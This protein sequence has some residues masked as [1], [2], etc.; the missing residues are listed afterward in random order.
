MD[1]CKC[2]APGTG[3]GPVGTTRILR[4]S[5]SCWIVHVPRALSL[6]SQHWQR[7]LPLSSCHLSRSLSLYIYMYIYIHVYIYIY[8]F[9]ALSMHHTALRHIS[10]SL[11]LY[12]HIFIYI[13]IYIYTSSTDSASH[14]PSVSLSPHFQCLPRLVR[15]VTTCTGWGPVG[16]ARSLR[17]SR[18]A[19]MYTSTFT[20]IHICVYLSLHIYTCVYHTSSRVSSTYILILFAFITGN[21]SLEPL[22]EGLCAQI[23]VNLR[24]RVFGR[25]LFIYVYIYI[26]IYTRM[27]ITHLAECQAAISRETW[28]VHSIATG[29]GWGPVGRATGMM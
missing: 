13:Y 9:Q 29:T 1:M 11:L 28:L 24:W 2:V 23:H 6:S 21:S 3:W 10:L 19:H 14:T 15:S 17:G 18:H 4:G 16:R 5:L 26:C 12:I 7:T 8:V 22:I 27:H 25:N 20:Y